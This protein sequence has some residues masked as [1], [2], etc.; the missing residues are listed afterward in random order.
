MKT[1]SADSYPKLAVIGR[2]LIATVFIVSGLGKLAAPGATIGYI[3]AMGLP[4]PSLAFV[5]A[6]ALELAG[7]VLLI[8]GYHARTVAALLAAYSVLTALV[9]HHGFGDQNQ[10]FHFLKN[11]AMA[12]GLLQ[13]IAFGAGAY[14]L[15]NRRLVAAERTA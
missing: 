14:S 4:A 5:A 9:F 7:G 3:E 10:V 13:V 6:M 12:G 8:V 15:D 2:L 11:L 1:V